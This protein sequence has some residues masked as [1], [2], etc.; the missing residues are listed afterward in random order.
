MWINWGFTILF[1]TSLYSQLSTD[2]RTFLS[3]VA[4]TYREAPRYD[5]KGEISAELEFLGGEQKKESIL[6]YHF[7]TAIERP[8]RVRAQLLNPDLGVLLVSDGNTTWQVNMRPSRKE[9]RLTENTAGYLL[10]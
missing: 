4:E 1:T 7:L 6:K 2:P 10:I 5:F 3:Q 8:A 9:Y